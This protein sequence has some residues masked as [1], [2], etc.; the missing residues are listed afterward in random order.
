MMVISTRRMMETKTM[1]RGSST[2][3]AVFRTTTTTELR[4]FSEEG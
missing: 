1:T 2:R 3:M 4:D